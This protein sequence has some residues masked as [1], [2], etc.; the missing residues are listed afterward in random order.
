MCQG[1]CQGSI[2][3]LPTQF[4]YKFFQEC[5]MCSPRRKIWHP[6]CGLLVI[7]RLVD[8]RGLLYGTN[9]ISY[10]LFCDIIFSLM[11]IICCIQYIYLKKII[12]LPGD[13]GRCGSVDNVVEGSIQKQNF[14]FSS[15]RMY[16]LIKCTNSY[17]L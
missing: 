11:R 7:D 1:A 13:T 2:N 17:I 8:F 12:V 15:Y 5:H 6:L 16:K 10:N 9:L 3:W 4:I 14:Y